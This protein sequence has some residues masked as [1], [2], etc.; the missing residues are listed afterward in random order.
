MAT[1]TPRFGFPIWLG[2]DAF[3]RADFNDIHQQIEDLGAICYVESGD[4]N[5][6]ADPGDAQYERAF[7][8]D[9]SANRLW[10]CDGSAWHATI[11]YGT[12]GQI[13]T[14]SI[15]G[16]AGAGTIDAAARADHQH[17]GPGFGSPSAT[18]A[19][20]ADGSATT[21]AR[22]DHVHAIGAGT[23]GTSALVASSVTATKLN[24]DVAGTGIK[25]AV[26]GSLE[27]NVGTGTLGTLD[28]YS[29]TVI[30]KEQALTQRHGATSLGT[31]AHRFIRTGNQPTTNVNTSILTGDLW[32]DTSGG[33]TDVKIQSAGN[34][35]VR[36]RNLPWGLIAKTE[37]T[38]SGSQTIAGGDPS[39]P[40][41]VN[42]A[43][44]A[45]SVTPTM[46]SDRLYRIRG[47]I[48]S[49]AH[50]VASLRTII[51]YLRG[52]STTYQRSLMRFEQSSLGQSMSVERIVAGPNTST[53]W[54]IALSF[55]STQFGNIT[56]NLNSLLETASLTVEDL[57]PITL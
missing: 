7:W 35:W 41:A 19:S 23:V 4:P 20:N 30:V 43:S 1:N 57:G 44:T 15:T 36:P 47:F 5:D 26:D 39:S 54:S 28:L 27:V 42:I 46:Y 56:V 49:I 53:T 21:V 14:N 37:I 13:T 51:M 25:R 33:R 29:D 52:N 38:S 50:D 8:Y 6:S 3:Q 24:N 9:T 45:L 16:A 34:E 12:S 32:V 17:A 10:F 18:G 31:A 48:P 22:S 11:T 2:T 40:T 55:D